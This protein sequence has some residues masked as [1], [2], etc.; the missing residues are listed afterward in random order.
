MVVV[1]IVVVLAIGFKVN[2]GE[3]NGGI[4]ERFPSV[5]ERASQIFRH[6][7]CL[8]LET[9]YMMVSLQSSQDLL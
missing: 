1:V 7:L 4:G 5:E 9:I 2:E 3:V 8:L 6:T